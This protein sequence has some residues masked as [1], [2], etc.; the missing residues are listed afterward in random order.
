MNQQPQGWSRERAL[1]FQMPYGKYMNTT[2]GELARVD[3]GYLR[4]VAETI[5]GNPGRAA[6]VLLGLPLEGGNS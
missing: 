3:P 6:R 1:A 5:D 4:W 2:L